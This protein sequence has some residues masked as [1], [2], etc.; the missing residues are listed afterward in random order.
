MSYEAKTVNLTITT[1]NN[2]ELYVSLAIKDNELINL[3]PKM[4]QL[5]RIPIHIKY[6]DGSKVPDFQIEPG[7][8]NYFISKIRLT[9]LATKEFS[10][11]FQILGMS[12]LKRIAAAWQIEKDIRKT[13]EELSKQPF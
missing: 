1:E 8:V 5:R 2:E 3:F 12:L 6:D 7:F 10:N 4:H 13:L 11:A 9:P